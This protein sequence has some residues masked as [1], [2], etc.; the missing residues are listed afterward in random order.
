MGGAVVTLPAVVALIGCVVD[1]DRPPGIGNE[2]PNTHGVDQ[3]PVASSSSSSSS[4]SSG[5]TGTGGTGGS[6]GTG[7]AGGSTSSSSSSSSSGTPANVCECSVAMNDTNTPNCGTC[8]T[9]AV[10]SACATEQLNCFNDTACGTVNGCVSSCGSTD[11]TCIDGCINNNAAYIALA[12]CI[13]QACGG[14]CTV[15]APVTCASG[16]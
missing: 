12:N 6:M 4:S 3:T 2:V 10:G 8:A 9:A 1:S 15:A 11:G 7:G 14:F 13:C 16:P 5:T